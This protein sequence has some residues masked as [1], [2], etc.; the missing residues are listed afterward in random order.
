MSNK[1]TVAVNP[2]KSSTTIAGPT[3]TAQNP[4]AQPAP[5]VPHRIPSLFAPATPAMLR[6]SDVRPQLVVPPVSALK[7]KEARLGSSL[8]RRT[9]GRSPPYTPKGD[10]SDDSP[11]SPFRV[12]SG[13]LTSDSSFFSAVLDEL[14]IPAP[15][16]TK[17]I[18]E[19]P[20]H[21]IHPTINP[22]ETPLQAVTRIMNQC[23]RSLSSTKGL[24]VS[25]THLTG[26][27]L[28]TVQHWDS[29][30]CDVVGALRFMESILKSMRRNSE[31][32]KR[33]DEIIVH[34]YHEDYEDSILVGLLKRLYR[35]HG[36]SDSPLSLVPFKV[37]FT[38]PCI[39][40]Q[41]CHDVQVW[42]VR[43]AWP[44]PKD[45]KTAAQTVGG[46]SEA[47]M[48]NAD[49]D[50]LVHGPKLALCVDVAGE[51]DETPKPGL[52]SVNRLV[53]RTI[54]PHMARKF[55]WDWDAGLCVANMFSR[56]LEESPSA[57]NIV[58]PDGEVFG[59][60]LLV[61][62]DSSSFERA[63][64]EVPR[65]LWTCEG[66]L[67]Y[68]SVLHSER[69]YWATGSLYFDN[70]RHSTYPAPVPT[71]SIVYIRIEDLA[72]VWRACGP[73]TAS[74]SL[75]V[76]RSCVLQQLN[77]HGGYDAYVGEDVVLAAF[78]ETLPAIEF[79]A[80]LQGTLCHADWSQSLLSVP[81]WGEVVGVTGTV[82]FRGL[83]CCIGMYAGNI[84]TQT[85]G[86]RTTYHGPVVEAAEK[87][88]LLASGGEVLCTAHLL[89]RDTDLKG[90][91]KHHLDVQSLGT[92]LLSAYDLVEVM[93]L[94]PKSLRER[95]DH[96]KHDSDSDGQQAPDFHDFLEHEAVDANEKLRHTVEM[97]QALIRRGIGP[98][99]RGS[100]GFMIVHFG[101]ENSALWCD[102]DDGLEHVVFM[103]KE[104]HRVVSQFGGQEVRSN[105]DS[106][107]AVF[108]ESE[109]AAQAAL[110]LV[111]LEHGHRIGVHT[112][113]PQFDENTLYGGPA[114]NRAV[115]IAE[116][117]RCDEIVMDVDTKKVV[118]A[119]RSALGEVC[120]TRIGMRHLHGN[121][122][123]ADL[124]TLT[125]GN[126]IKLG[127]RAR[128]DLSE[129][130]DPLSSSITSE[131]LVWSTE[132]D[133]GPKGDD[134]EVL[135]GDT[136]EALRA[137]DELWR[138]HRIFRDFFTMLSSVTEGNMEA[139]EL[140]ERSTRRCFDVVL[141]G[142]ELASSRELDFPA[143]QEEILREVIDE[144]GLEDAVRGVAE[145]RAVSNSLCG[146]MVR[147]MKKLC[148]LTGD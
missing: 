132:K 102:H 68:N 13:V 50:I 128:G 137:C 18:T 142:T 73:S 55:A 133:E 114:Y 22:K 64:R 93:R 82:V 145:W 14:H 43:L 139:R 113:T 4:Y 135:S 49:G 81:K 31:T 136:I 105:G 86:I 32:A 99:P 118:A 46:A 140:L 21:T 138:F 125:G 110:S 2:S 52:I 9:S 67:E 38:D 83:R 115:R 95:R 58:A 20:A 34:V 10:G 147:F 127:A 87:L 111:R 36:C 129:H 75:D 72:E 3:F 42:S 103:S 92:Q 108:A 8:S 60:G 47:A 30:T 126:P 44:G 54:T 53:Q 76:F 100:V 27:E 119:A 63:W 148:A 59:G 25:P 96:I 11:M 117:A 6:Q 15:T 131:D 51:D 85:R 79:C 16:T 144:V 109:K 112:A 39:A 35:H 101:P 40:M 123:P 89:E 41:F 62:A 124:Y 24:K 23:I 66:Y 33:C 122:E 106:L 65:S 78:G 70:K 77:Q 116:Y 130:L 5:R 28:K 7:K 56:R 29:V 143:F 120:F 69:L 17:S 57:Y 12:P 104:A 19:L 91:I 37:K 45:E 26:A 121:R 107:V 90:Y 146:L 48:Q 1:R 61:P 84:Q 94:I 141:V 88:C 98:F 71:A 134:E 80:S 74:H 97:Q